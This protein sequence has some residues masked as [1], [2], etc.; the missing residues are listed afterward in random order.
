MGRLRVTVLSVLAL[1][2]VPATSPAKG[3][4]YLVHAGAG[5]GK[6][7]DAGA[8]GGSVGFSA[9]L[10]YRLP[11]STRFGIG[12]EVGYQWL[13]SVSRERR[14]GANNA[15]VTWTEEWTMIPTMASIFYFPREQGP[16]PLLS[17]G[18]GFYPMKV[19]SSLGESVG[20]EDSDP[21][22]HLGVGLL[23]GD[24]GSVVRPGIEAR[25]HVIRTGGGA[26]SDLLTVVLRAWF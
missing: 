24:S 9:G 6:V 20:T 15:P 16:A 26:S 5:Y 21:G 3:K 7:L 19:G 1:L 4:S 22:L 18:L 8:P 23:F 14:G 17:A 2:V 11:V 10:I 13:G 12:A 25:Y